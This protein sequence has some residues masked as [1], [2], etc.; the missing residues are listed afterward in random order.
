M[1]GADDKF[2]H[3]SISQFSP[4]DADSYIEYELFLNTIREIVQPIVDAPPPQLGSSWSDNRRNICTIKDLVKV[5]YRNKQCLVPFLELMVAPAT[6]L[7]N[8]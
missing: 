1:L 3:S 6:V 7:L 8:R 5:G 4:R 2:N